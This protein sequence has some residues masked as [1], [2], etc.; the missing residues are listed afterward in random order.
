MQTPSPDAAGPASLASGV[1]RRRVIVVAGAALLAG[2]AIAALTL[3]PFVRRTPAPSA[4]SGV[5]LGGPQVSI[6]PRPSPDGHLLAFVGNDVDDV[7]QLWVAKPESGNRIMLTHNRERGY[8]NSCS[9]SSDGNRIYYDR[10]FDGPKGIFSVPA[11]GGEEQLVVEDAMFPEPLPDGSLL[12]VR[13]NPENRRQLFRYWPDSGKLQGY[14]VQ[15]TAAPSG[16]RSVRDG[17]RALV[18]G[19]ATAPGADRGVHAWIVDVLSGELRRLPVDLSNVSNTSIAA[20]WDGKRALIGFV[21]GSLYRVVSVP[22]DRS[23]D[24]RPTALVTSTLSAFTID[25][26]SDDS[27]YVEQNDRPI[28]LVRFTL[29]SSASGE[30]SGRAGGVHVDRIA[31]LA[32][33]GLATMQSDSFAVLP[34]GRAV[35]T[36]VNGGRKRVM[37][38]E[39]GKDPVPLVSTS[40]ETFGPMT[41]VGAG[42]VAFMIGSNG[43]PAIGLAALATGRITRQLSFDKGSVSS[44]AA[45]P[46]GN[47]IYAVAEGLVWAL[48]ITGEAPRK[49]RSGDGVTVDIATQSLVVFVQKP[50][51]NRLIRIPLAGGPEQEIAGSFRLGGVVDPGSIRN[52]RLVSPLAGPYWYWP[53]GIFDLATGRSERIPLDY[54]EDFHHM[55]WTPDGSVMAVAVGFRASIWKF[56][57][58]GK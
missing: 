22:L 48:P 15:P 4:W 29:G 10:W 35:W 51:R 39:A 56:T 46:D 43:N 7:L 47:T 9:W 12:L 3:G 27:I 25:A 33:S 23:A 20:T 18:I 49:I 32:S 58:E 21:S 17:R 13:I 14:A 37:V 31:T 19:V 42:E 50:G 53:P 36:E 55:A 1:S 54:K 40:E 8:V 34:D 44:M 38:V 41:A 24:Q 28:E 6:S 30:R 57:P 16:P 52:G 11:L 45:S 26:G 2:V 5:M